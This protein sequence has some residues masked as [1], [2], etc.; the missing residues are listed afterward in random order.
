MHVGKRLAVLIPHD[1]TA[2]EFF[3]EPRRLRAERH[4]DL[5]RRAGVE[6]STW[7]RAALCLASHSVTEAIPA[8][9]ICGIVDD[10][11]Q[12]PSIVAALIREM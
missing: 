3:D 1:D 7:A 11:L 2:V 8:H 5:C 6:L 9:A 12:S 10:W 4:R